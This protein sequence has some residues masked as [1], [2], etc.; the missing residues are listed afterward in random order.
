L[1]HF[2]ELVARVEEDLLSVTGVGNGLV[3][4]VAGGRVR[5][6]GEGEG[7]EGKE[8]SKRERREALE[9]FDELVAGVEEY[10]LSVNGSW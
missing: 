8:G 6:R 3:L 1:E 2:D 7:E 10:F 4:V 5:R 9:H